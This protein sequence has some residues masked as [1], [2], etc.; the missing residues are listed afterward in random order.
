MRRRRRAEERRHLRRC[1][2]GLVGCAGPAGR[3]IERNAAAPGIG[4][5]FGAATRI[6]QAIAGRHIHQQERIEPDPVAACFQFRDRLQHGVVA[7]RAAKRGRAFELADEARA[8]AIDAARA[9]LEGHGEL[10]A[11]FYAGP[12]LTFAAAQIV[13]EPRHHQQ[14]RLAI[15]KVRRQL[16]ERYEQIGAIAFGVDVLRRLLAW[17]K[18][19][20]HRLGRVHELARAGDEAHTLDALFE[21]R[22]IAGRGT[23]DLERKLRHRIAEALERHVLEDNV[24]QAAIG[25]RVVGALDGFNQRVERLILRA[26][27]E[28]PD[29]LGQIERLTVGPDAADARDFA[30]TKPD[31]KGKRV[32][33]GG[34]RRARPTLAA[35]IAR[36][37]ALLEARR[38]DH[39]AGDAH[40]PE[41]GG[42]RSP[43][44]GALQMQIG[45]PRALPVRR[46]SEQLLI[47]RASE[48]GAAGAPERCADRADHAWQAGA[49][50]LADGGEN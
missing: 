45:K 34:D 22:P 50:G 10:E 38:P 14:H 32:A 41:H 9:P 2:R 6:G 8:A 16:V 26:G 39:L 17:P 47:D 27:M 15:G 25:G 28:T 5:L 23:D 43:F 44:G 29:E 1:R 21:A 40:P 35:D 11:D 42:D 20:Q 36:V 30:F 4:R 7:R 12:D 48:P 46:Q 19:A 13:A 3:G 37:G 24:S 33:I 31:S 49:D 18:R